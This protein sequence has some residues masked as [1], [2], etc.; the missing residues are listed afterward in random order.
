MNPGEKLRRWRQSRLGRTAGKAHAVADGAYQALTRPDRPLT[1]ETHKKPW[2]AALLS[3]I[4]VG[5]GQLY[6]RQLAR[7]VFLFV[8][9]YLGGGLLLLV[10]L[11]LH[12]LLALGDRLPGWATT[13]SERLLDAAPAFELLWAGLWLFAVAD[14]WRVARALRAGRLV[15]RYS[16]RRQAAFL[17][18]RL[19][20]FAGTL[21]PDETVTPDEAHQSLNDAVVG[22]AKEYVADRLLWRVVRYGGL[23]LG[24]LLVVIG[25][26]AGLTWVVGLGAVAFAAVIL[27]YLI[28]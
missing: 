16:F 13:A 11:L 15:V 23:G 5:S 21:A 26:A 27:S 8:L 2:L 9:F 12:G 24:V 18:A 4:I 10:A 3:L 20:P 17:A 7:A 6:N 28:G 1:P 22:A 25:L 19:I 14:A